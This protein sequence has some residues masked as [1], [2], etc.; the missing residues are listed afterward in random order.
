MI[1]QV[2]FVLWLF[3]SLHDLL[4]ELLM[5]D[6]IY[7]IRLVPSYRHHRAAAFPL[8]RRDG[9]QTTLFDS[10]MTVENWSRMTPCLDAPPMI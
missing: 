8:A 5:Y 9:T 6:M 1:N 10:V 7:H 4:N 3:C 2:P